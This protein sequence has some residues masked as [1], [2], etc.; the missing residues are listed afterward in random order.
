MTQNQRIRRP[1]RKPCIGDMRERIVLQTRDIQAPVYGDPDF[2][3][4]FAQLEPVWAS[5]V[6]TPT[7][8][9]FD[10]ANTDVN[11]SH[12]IVVRADPRIT[13]ETWILLEDGKRLDVVRSESIDERGEFVQMLCN[14]RGDVSVEAARA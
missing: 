14:E 2:T 1:R 13:T 7:T 11:V 8:T 9:V 4:K 5:I 12:K 10:G 3:E 6:T